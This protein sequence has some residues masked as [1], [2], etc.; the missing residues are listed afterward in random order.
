MTKVSASKERVNASLIYKILLTKSHAHC[1]L[2]QTER[3]SHTAYPDQGSMSL[4]FHHYILK[5]Y[6]C[7]ITMAIS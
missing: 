4:P 5:P 2:Y 3:P 6:D 1:L 7:M